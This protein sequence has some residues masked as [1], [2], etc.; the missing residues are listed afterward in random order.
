MAGSSPRFSLEHGTT[1][2]PLVSA[3]TT[4]GSGPRC[5]IVLH[6]EAVEELHA[7][8]VLEDDSIVLEDRSEKGTVRVNG[9]PARSAQLEDG[10][11][12]TFGEVELTVESSDA[13]NFLTGGGERY[14]LRPGENR[15]GRT[16]DA[17]P[18]IEDESVSREH[19]LLAVLPSGQIWVRDLR[20]SN[21]TFVGD[22][23]L[24]EWRLKDGDE[25]EI[26]GEKLTFS[27]NQPSPEAKKYA[28][29]Q[30]I[31]TAGA[32]VMELLIAGKPMVLENGRITLGRT[33]ECDVTF[34]DGAAVSREHA[35][36]LVGG[37]Q[38]V[39]DDLGS[40]NGTLV[41]GTRITGSTV[42]AN[43][44]K[45]AIGTHE[46]EFR[47]SGGGAAPP[48]KYAPTQ[49]LS[50]P[51]APAQTSPPPGTK[52]SVVTIDD[53]RRKAYELLDL[54]ASADEAAIR[55]RY[56]ER[57]SDF[58][59]RLDNAPTPELKKTYGDK[60]A[61]LKRAVATIA[62]DVLAVP[63]AADLPAAQPVHRTS[64]IE[65]STP[66]APPAAAEKPEKKHPSRPTALDQTPGQK[67][68]I[69]PSTLV[70]GIIGALMIAATAIFMYLYLQAADVEAG[71]QEDLAQRQEV[72]VGLEQQIPTV[73]AALEELQQN[74]A[75][76][77]ENAEVKICNLSS[78][79]MIVRWLN[80]TYVDPTGRFVT[81][82]SAWDELGW[83]KWTI[84]PGQTFKT[85]VV[86]GTQVIWDGEA[87][88]FSVLLLYQG[89]EIFRAGAIPTLGGEC[90][91]V[92]LD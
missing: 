61:A 70:M 68:K 72:I 18:L 65:S 91:A 26:G 77:L 16:A 27:E 50:P 43:G 30:I 22:R 46:I 13:G 71:L 92:D 25:V 29:T 39:I 60:L 67:A 57:F 51:G 78:K 3:E 17:N 52:E 62:P 2:H 85:Q 66:H 55:T 8:A 7:A 36:I 31:G 87:V 21:G 14:T 81:F 49:M 88:F 10:D 79:E 19:A 42:L 83:D 24:G 40:S 33:D 74:K 15:V 89:Q 59:I 1:S 9:I 12:I 75:Q 76:L 44:D 23:R 45:I 28:A 63:S 73:E 20:S 32:T 54:D 58:R 84:G 6:G 48:P 86:R 69:L 47:A 90:Y 82:D 41:N 34:A 53:Q 5:G 35:S 80:A 11:R 38:A 37:S 56:Q 64:T 4:I